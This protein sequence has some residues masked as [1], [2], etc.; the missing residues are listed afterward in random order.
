MMSRALLL[1]VFRACCFCLITRSFQLSPLGIAPTLGAKSKRIALVA[2][3]PLIT[4][5]QP[6]QALLMQLLLFSAW[7][8]GKPHL[9]VPLQKNQLATPPPSC[10]YSA[11]AGTSCSYCGSACYCCCARY[12]AFAVPVFEIAYKTIG[13]GFSW[14]FHSIKNRVPVTDEPGFCYVSMGWVTTA[15]R[16]RSICAAGFPD[17]G[18]VPIG[19]CG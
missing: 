7:L 18:D 17:A 8:W 9:A 10:I 3:L 2:V 13:Y 4:G 15:T 5:I 14:C 19:I 16:W 6:V 12:K 11:R 1:L